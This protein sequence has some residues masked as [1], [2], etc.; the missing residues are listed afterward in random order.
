MIEF[1]AGLASGA[2]F[3][4]VYVAFKAPSVAS[5][6]FSDLQATLLALNEKNAGERTILMQQHQI[7]R[8]ELLN[9]IKPETSQYPVL[10]EAAQVKA[11]E[12]DNDDDFWNS[13]A[14]SPQT[15]KLMEEAMA[16]GLTE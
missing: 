12:P 14:V 1:L 9:R 15:R 5:K 3:G 8:A 6:A 2:L 11:V 10:A 16:V 13:D 4:A 7:E